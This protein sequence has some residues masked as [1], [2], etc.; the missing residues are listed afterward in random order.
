MTEAPNS[1]G[2]E[3]GE[4]RLVRLLVENGDSSV[5]DVQ[6]MILREV[7]GFCHGNWQDDAT[8]ILIAVE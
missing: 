2:E 6:K 1:D 7:G 4:A 5:Q 8:L 3:F